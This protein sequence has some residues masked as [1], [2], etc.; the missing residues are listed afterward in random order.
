MRST[1]A[2]VVAAL[3]FI[4][5]PVQ[6]RAQEDAAR[7][8]SLLTGEELAATG[9]TTLHAAVRVLRPQWLR[10]R[11]STERRAD[12][13]VDSVLSRDSTVLHTLRP[14]DVRW[15]QYSTPGEARV[16]FDTLNRSGVL[17]VSTRLPVSAA[18]ARVPQAAPFQAR[19][20]I[21]VS[22]LASR[23]VGRTQALENKEGS[24]AGVA[25]SFPLNAGT[26][27]VA[28]LEHGRMTGACPC[29]GGEAPPDEAGVLLGAEVGVKLYSGGSRA[30]APYVSALLGV[31]QAE[32]KPIVL[33]G[34]T[35]RQGF[36]ERGL[37]GSAGAGVDVRLGARLLL[38]SEARFSV[39]GL[40]GRAARRGSL[41]LGTTVLV[42]R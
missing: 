10:F 31:H 9:R 8:P 15:V 23:G 40:A 20:G 38:N 26:A 2:L 1:P 41:R 28:S 37:G 14:Q 39:M 25:A 17:H 19:P 7:D 33:E 5:L 35:Y 3:V 4:C 24:G 32:W 36:T 18:H 13:Y 21:T 42:G 16:R 30:Y 27:L 11:R 34:L 22:G 12:V 29:G 6:A